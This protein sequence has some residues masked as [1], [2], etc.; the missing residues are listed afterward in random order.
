MDF[1]QIET[2]FI[3]FAKIILLSLSKLDILYLR[4]NFLIKFV[5]IFTNLDCF[6]LEYSES[7]L[8]QNFLINLFHFF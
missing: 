2:R 4:I 1:G 3:E 7:E 6:K 8:W 5:F